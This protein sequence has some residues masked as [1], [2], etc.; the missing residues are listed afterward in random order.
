MGGTAAPGA[1]LPALRAAVYRPGATAADI[2]ALEAA[3]AA[4]DRPRAEAPAARAAATSGD[5]HPG[6]LT[7]SG[8]RRRWVAV[9]AA[10]GAAAGGCAAGVALALLARP[11]GS[12]A[13]TV[14]TVVH[15]ATTATGAVFARPQRAADRP[16]VPLDPTVVPASTRRLLGAGRIAL[17]A[18]EDRS[19]R[20][21]LVGVQGGSAL[22]CVAPDRFSRSGVRL[23]WS[24][25]VL[26]VD[27]AAL[28]ELTSRLTL[29]AEWR[30]DGRVLLGAVLP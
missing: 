6:E 24:S 9:L 26:A 25:D 12:A 19:G 5:A 17:Y 15:I 13:A 22:S 21:C 11:A 28:R 2:R 10:A 14:P 20:R 23:L 4:L 18:A 1:D 8:R 3:L 29:A 16:G 27:P 7:A 30:P